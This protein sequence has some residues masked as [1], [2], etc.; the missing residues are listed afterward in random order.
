MLLVTADFDVGTPTEKATF[1]WKTQLNHS[2]L[3]VRHG[4]DHTSFN[5]KPLV[6]RLSCNFLAPFEDDLSSI[7]DIPCAPTVPTAPSTL[8]T[9]EFL[10]TGI[11]PTK[12]NTTLVTVYEPHAKRAPIPDPYDVPTGLV[13]GDCPEANEC[14]L[15]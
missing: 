8:I 11:L 13:A 6:I 2:A 1:M 12:R 9:K 14:G 4:D 5:C 15:V 7:T 3:V 10:R